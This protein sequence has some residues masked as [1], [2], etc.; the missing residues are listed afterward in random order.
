MTTTADKAQTLA[1]LHAAPEILQVVNVWDAVSAKTIAALPETRAIA[2][3]G[4]SI[5][6]TFG[7]ADGENIPLEI[8][9][10]LVGRIVDAVGDLPVSADLDAGFGDAGDT[11]RRA[12]GVGVVGANIED[13]LRPLDESVAV[14]EAAIAAG[15]AEGVPFVL[16]ARTDAFVRA[17]GRP[18][19]E[20]IADAIERGRAYLA[21]G[22]DLVFV[23][24][25]LDAAVT[26]Q[27]VDG[28]GERKIS[29]IGLPGALS[30]GE[31]EALGVAR[32]SYGPMT[33]RVALTALQDAAAALYAGGVIPAETRALN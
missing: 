12:I 9:L 21:A 24:G 11:V 10:D 16:N 20:S 19:E 28:I 33:Q 5:A 30:A 15:E 1:R 26:R 22:A 2:T 29:V 18:V 3:A 7:Y 17:G 27:L 14:V 23:P 6:A 31:Y 13:R 32:V 25:I 4:H 8:M